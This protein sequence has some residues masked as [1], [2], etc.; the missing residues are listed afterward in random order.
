VLKNTDYAFLV[1]L[2]DGI[3]SM[4]SDQEIIDLVRG[5]ATPA[6]AAKAIVGFAEMLGGEDNMTCI[7]AP[8]SGWNKVAG[9]DQTKERRQFRLDRASTNSRQRRM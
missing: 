7:V 6:Q 3:T 9:T 8:L 4:M 1:L 2:S 5:N